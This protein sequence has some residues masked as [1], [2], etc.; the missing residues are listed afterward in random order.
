MSEDQVELFRAAPDVG[1]GPRWHVLGT[2]LHGFMLVAPLPCG[3]IQAAIQSEQHTV[4]RARLVSGE[5][6]TL[7]RRICRH[8]L[9]AVRQAK[10][11]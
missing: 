11:A 10:A 5:V 7:E 4:A 1:L 6:A 3:F 9:T 8:C 2:R